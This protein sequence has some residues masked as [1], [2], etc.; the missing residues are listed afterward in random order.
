MDA[1]SEQVDGFQSDRLNVSSAKVMEELLV[2][3]EINRL[4]FLAWCNQHHIKIPQLPYRPD[5]VLAML[6]KDKE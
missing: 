1:E 5:P 2:I 4:K 6:N 3:Q